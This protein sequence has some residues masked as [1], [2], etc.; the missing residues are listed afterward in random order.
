VRPFRIGPVLSVASISGSSFKFLLHTNL[1]DYNFP[2]MP[3]GSLYDSLTII[4]LL[5]THRSIS[6]VSFILQPRP[7]PLVPIG[8]QVFLGHSIFFPAAGSVHVPYTN[9]A[10]QHTE[11]MFPCTQMS[12]VP[13]GASIPDAWLVCCSFPPTSPCLLGLSSSVYHM[14]F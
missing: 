11:Q 3:V 10:V 8:T 12:R 9:G 7:S 4:S 14:L 6:A 1:F 13:R 2:H 5:P